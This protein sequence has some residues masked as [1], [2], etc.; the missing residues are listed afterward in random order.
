MNKIFSI[1]L[2]NS[3]IV[4]LLVFTI[5]FS[6]FGF[7]TKSFQYLNISN[8]DTTDIYANDNYLRYDDYTYN[9]N[10]KTVLLYN[11]R[12]ELSY[13]TLPLNSSEKL[14]LSFDDFNT[15]LK[16]YYYTFIH[17]NV[18]WT[19]SDLSPNQYL[20]NYTEDDIKE[21]KYSFNTDK[22]FIHYNLTFPN[23]N[24]SIKLS[25]NYIIKVYDSDYPD[26]AVITKRFLVYENHADVNITIKP[27]VN[28][29]ERFTRQE[30]D[31]EVNHNN[32]EIN[33]PYQNITVI[34]M[35][36]Y[37]WDNAI[38]GLKPKFINGSLLDYNYEAVNVFD[39]NN[40]FRNFD[41]KSMNFNS[42]NVYRVQYD[43]AEK[44]MNIILYEDLPRA[45]RK[46]YAQPDL[47]GNFLVK[48]DD[49]NDS[50]TDAEYVNVTFNLKR[51]TLRYGGN[52]YLFGKFTDW[53]F[54]EEFKM[55]YDTINKQYQQ[56]VLLK[57]G[58]YN[59]MYCFVKDGSKNVGDIS[60]IEGTYYETENDYTV[61]V[62]YRNPMENFDQ[63][64]GM[65]TRN[66][67]K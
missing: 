43:N 21:Y 31:F 59:Y 62:Y 57:Q 45:F 55:A 20:D 12:D 7:K 44:M 50:E 28:P 38:S 22:A 54:K 58:Y 47:N 46:H 24:I 41:I 10:I 4:F 16:T 33:N 3:L 36:N 23:E 15:S 56:T 9:K 11:L 35:Q 60:Y 5:S 49:S 63:L 32:Y 51:D 48:R 39:G 34:L 14:K 65:K 19:P 18:N 66:T 26:E 52:I 13:P 42:Q 37:R 30:I 64:I 17:C 1:F 29:N 40:E 67:N 6:F 27:S 25:G 8:N 53:K 61:L 2:K